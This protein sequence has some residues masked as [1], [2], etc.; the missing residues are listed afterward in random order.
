MQQIKTALCS[1]GMSGL[2]FHAPFI[3]VH[4]GFE[5]YGVFERTKSLAQ[6]KYPGIKTFRFIKRACW[7]MMRLNW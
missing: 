7:Q 1:F 6:E 5:L 3:D 2:L 4:E